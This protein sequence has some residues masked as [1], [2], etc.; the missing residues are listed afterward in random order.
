VKNSEPKD[1]LESARET[2]TSNWGV[3][4]ALWSIACSLIAIG[5]A[6]RDIRDIQK[7]KAV[8]RVRD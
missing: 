3:P 8:E 6:L 7:G 2:L 4:T 5:D 1:P